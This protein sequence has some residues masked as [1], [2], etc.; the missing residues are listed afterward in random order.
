MRSLSRALCTMLL[1][2]KTTCA[3]DNFLGTWTPNVAKSKY[4]PGPPPNS[5]TT[6][7][8][9]TNRGVGVIFFDRK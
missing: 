6:K 4:D 3:A 9:A 5:Q 1:L 7:L 8:E 2:A